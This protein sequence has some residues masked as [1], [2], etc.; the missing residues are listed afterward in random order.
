MTK[1]NELLQQLRQAKQVHEIFFLEIFLK[2]LRLKNL[3]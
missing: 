2:R 3:I 1:I